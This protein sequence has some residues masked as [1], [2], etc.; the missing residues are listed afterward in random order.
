MQQHQIQPFVQECLLGR[1]G[2]LVGS[3]ELFQEH[4]KLLPVASIPCI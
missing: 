1:L 3:G 2:I 4:L